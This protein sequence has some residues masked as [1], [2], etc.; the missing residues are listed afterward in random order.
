ML[1]SSNLTR[2]WGHC[3]HFTDQEFHCA[4]TVCMHFIDHEFKGSRAVI[5]YQWKKNAKT[6]LNELSGS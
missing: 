4:R 5:N 2:N 6:Y 1:Q 3:V